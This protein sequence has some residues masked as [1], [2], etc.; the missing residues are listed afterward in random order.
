MQHTPEI[1]MEINESIALLGAELDACWSALSPLLNSE[2]RAA[3]AKVLVHGFAAVKEYDRRKTEGLAAIRALLD[4]YQTTE[5]ERLKFLVDAF[6]L[7]AKL[8]NTLHDEFHDI[9]GETQVARFTEAIVK[10]LD[11]IGTNRAPLAVLL[12]NPDVGVRAW[13]GACLINLQPDRVIPILRE[14]EEKEFANGA[15]F[16]AFFALLRWEREGKY[17]EDQKNSKLPGADA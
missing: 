2:D 12:E 15:H 13:A 8:A 9:N 5:S 4:R 16:T 17:A 6:A 14:I 10:T 11:G 1:A 7:A 3:Q